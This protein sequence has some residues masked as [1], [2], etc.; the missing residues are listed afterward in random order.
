V[1]Q[2]DSCDEAVANIQDTIKPW[3]EACIDAGE[4]V[5]R[6]INAFGLDRCV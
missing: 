5:P 2:D 1:S 3:L 6:I 4:P